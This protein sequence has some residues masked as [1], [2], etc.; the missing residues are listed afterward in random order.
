MDTNRLS[1]EF[2]LIIRDGVDF[3]P[4]QFD[5]VGV[6]SQRVREAS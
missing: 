5:V 4:T 1:A 3:T 2:L 6:Y